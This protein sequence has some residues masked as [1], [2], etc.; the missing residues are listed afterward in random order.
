MLD[1]SFDQQMYDIALPL[2]SQLRK[3]IDVAMLETVQSECVAADPVQLPRRAVEP[4]PERGAEAQ[5]GRT[6][7]RP[8][9][10]SPLPTRLRDLAATWEDCPH[11]SH[12]LDG[13]ME[14]DVL[15]QNGVCRPLPF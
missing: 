1:V 5:I 11:L 12:P 8:S 6:V 3:P 10:G 4:P 7:A 14:E 15:A 13:G 2:G 9:Q